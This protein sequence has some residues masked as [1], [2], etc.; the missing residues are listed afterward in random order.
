MIGKIKS[1]EEDAQWVREI[2]QQVVAMVLTAGALCTRFHNRVV[3][4]ARLLRPSLGPWKKSILPFFGM[5][6]QCIT[7][8]RYCKPLVQIDS[9][10]LYG[11]Y[12]YKLLIAVAQDGNRRI[13]PIT[14]IITPK[15]FGDD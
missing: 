14:L 15:E 7:A 1:F 8:F 2:L 13:L 6:Q 12:E 5:F 4:G 10:F 11:R 3:D 9:I